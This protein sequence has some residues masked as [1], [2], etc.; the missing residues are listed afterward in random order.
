MFK[1][2]TKIEENAVLYKRNKAEKVVFGF[3]FVTFALYAFSLIFPLLWLLVN[4][5]QDKIVYEINLA[6]GEAFALPD[7]LDWSNYVYA[8]EELESSGTNIFGMFFNTIWYVGVRVGGCVLMASCTGYALSKYNFKLKNL[9][10]AVIIFSMTTPVVGTTG[11]S[12]R[13]VNDLMGIYDTPL[14]PLLKYLTGTG[15]N[16]LIMY[17]FFKNVSW[18]YAE[19]AFMDGASHSKVF[20]HIMLPQALPAVVTLCVLSGIGAWNEYMDVLLYLPSFPT[21]ASG[22]YSVSRTLPRLGNSPAYFAALV[23]SLV[24]VLTIFFFCSD[25]IMKNFAVGGLKG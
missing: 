16:F 24:P 15:T 22:L 3:V 9:M 6:N 1:R 5:L 12:F 4:S 18:S 10:Y 19:A 20:F 13:L 23:I 25:I 8:F 21:I 14:Y 11:A 7:K 2:K 17:G